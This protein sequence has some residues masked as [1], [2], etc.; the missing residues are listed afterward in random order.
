MAS[1]EGRA[2]RS[3]GLGLGNVLF[4]SLL[5]AFLFAACG[6]GA[7]FSGSS[8]AQPAKKATKAAPDPQ[9]AK[10]KPEK[11]QASRPVAEEEPRDADAVADVGVALPPE[12][13]QLSWH[14]PCVPTSTK[15]PSLT[16]DASNAIDGGGEHRLVASADDSVAIDFSGEICPPEQQARDIV[17]VI[18]TSTSMNQNDPLLQGSCARM[19]AVRQVMA[20]LAGGNV[21]F[22]VTT[23]SLT[24]NQ[25][26][27]ALYP[28]EQQLFQ[29]LAGAG[30]AAQVLCFANPEAGT[31]YD[32]GLNAAATLL[33]QGRPGATKE[34]YLVSDGQPNGGD[35]IAVAQGLK[36]GGVLIGSNWLKVTIAGVMLNGQDTVMEQYIASIGANGKPLYAYAA[37]ADSLAGVLEGL[38][39]NEI[40]HASL[41]HRPRGSKTWNKV[42]LLPQLSGFNFALPSINI[43]VAEAKQGLDVAVEYG[44]R[45]NNRFVSE[46]KLVWQDAAAGE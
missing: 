43:D 27:K 2:D 14:W 8:G 37:L 31:N 5:L 42:D 13:L 12:V 30:D 10:P 34:I 18:D 39:K 20:S 11:P 19:A 9:P 26:S 32:A 3:R 21:K 16:A 6:D 23:F 29:D 40:V 28:T 45:H 22:A 25:A 35:G 24:L 4:P 17:F 33:G 38:S 1:G 44:D 7:D 41:S 46:G 15:A 36:S